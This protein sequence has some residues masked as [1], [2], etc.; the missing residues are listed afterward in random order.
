MT[1]VLRFPNTT[2]GIIDFYFPTSQ[3]LFN[4]RI[5]GENVNEISMSLGNF[6]FE[7]RTII[8]Q[9]AVLYKQISA[10]RKMDGS[11]PFA[12]TFKIPSQDQEINYC[13]LK[14]I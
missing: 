14:L 7:T 13:S 4:I 6:D 10:D 8:E 5:Q 3:E 2:E 9:K 12:N 11:F 1:N